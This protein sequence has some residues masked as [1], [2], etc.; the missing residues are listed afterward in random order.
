MVSLGEIIM[1][2]VGWSTWALINSGQVI[3][4]GYFSPAGY[5]PVFGETVQFTH[6]SVII[7]LDHCLHSAKSSLEHETNV[8]TN[9]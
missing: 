8:R 3:H 7:I 5:L 4:V 1:G 9:C 6:G 2:A